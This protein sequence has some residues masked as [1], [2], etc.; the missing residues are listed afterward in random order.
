MEEKIVSIPVRTALMPIF[1]KDFHC[2]AADCRDNCCGGWKITFGKK[3]YLKIKR[4]ATSGEM[5]EILSSAMTRFRKHELG[6]ENYARFRMDNQDNCVF[7]TEEGLCRLQLE[8]GAECLPEVCREYPRKSFYTSAAKEL[9]LSPTCEAVLA[10]L[11]ELPQGIDFWEEDLPK[12]D[13]A[14]VSAPPRLVR[15]ADIRSF[16]IDVMQER[17]LPLSRRMLLLGLVIRRLTELDWT[18]G[19]VV[20]AWLA[21]GMGQLHDPRTA[22]V[23][24]NMPRD[25]LAFLTH[26]LRAALELYENAVPKAKGVYRSLFSALSADRETWEEKGLE[27]FR[28]DTIRY[29]KLERQLEGLLGHTDTFFENLMVSTA[30]YEIFPDPSG[31]EELWRSYAA[32]CGLYSIFW[33]AAVL[34][35]QKEVS[36]E[37]LFQVTVTV[38]RD[39][40]HNKTK[41]ERL[42]DAVLENDGTMDKISV[43][44]GG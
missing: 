6:D 24:E 11:W 13:W 15:F 21:W 26:N 2:L 4:T 14:T 40:L 35:C 27:R 1:Y 17:P 12:Q 32:M 42:T 29:Q 41:L 8:C 10:L 5:K 22:P 19:G 34:G 36:R 39:L 18:E 25:R 28:M 16:C 38:S 31:P 20:D 44:L 37:R 23:L 7:Q 9:S 33:F 30:F 43:L 3:D